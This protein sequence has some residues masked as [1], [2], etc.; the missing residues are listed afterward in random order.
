MASS[1]S[2]RNGAQPDWPPED[3]GEAANGHSKG[4][5]EP[6]IVKTGRVTG[7]RLW[8]QQ[9]RGAACAGWHQPTLLARRARRRLTWPRP[10][11]FAA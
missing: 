7:L 5:E 6:L 4:L 3:G 11:S 2:K 9:A 8:A 1:F 10:L